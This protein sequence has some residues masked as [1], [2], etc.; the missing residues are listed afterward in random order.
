MR[1]LPRPITAPDQ[2]ESPAGE[3]AIRE[4]A[5]PGSAPVSSRGMDSPAK[6]P[7]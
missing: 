7:S 4:D 5:R 6:G 1:A 3:G 2:V